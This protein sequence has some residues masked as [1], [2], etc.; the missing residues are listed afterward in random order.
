[1]MFYSPK[2][3][4][5]A[6]KFSSRC[7]FCAVLPSAASEEFSVAFNWTPITSY[8]GHFLNCLAA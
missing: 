8:V 5:H 6:E 1:M 4:T 7:L 2:L 3:E